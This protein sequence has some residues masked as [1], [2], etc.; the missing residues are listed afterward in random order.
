MILPGHNA[1]NP[2]FWLGEVDGDP[3][4]WEESGGVPPLFDGCH[5]K[6]WVS[7]NGD[8]PMVAGS[9]PCWMRI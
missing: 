6:L 4:H 1:G 3:L 9:T 8:N 5:G 7:N 2:D